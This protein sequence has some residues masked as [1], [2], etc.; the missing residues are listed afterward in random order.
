MS[1]TFFF[2]FKNI[3]EII[4][5][6]IQMLPVKVQVLCL[7]SMLGCHFCYSIGTKE[8]KDII[9][10]KKYN[11]TRN[12]F[13]EFMI[14]DENGKHYNVNNSLW[15]WKWNSIE[16]WSLLENNKKINIKYYGWRIPILG[17]FP[18]IVY[19][20]KIQKDGF[21]EEG[22]IITEKNFNEEGNMVYNNDCHI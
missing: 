2:R 9:I 20:R 17:I 5:N 12:G 8:E 10:N 16:D 21:N 6:N 3:H 13:T 18:N 15:F 1:R 4:D 11:F 19:S 22:I 14:V 7:A